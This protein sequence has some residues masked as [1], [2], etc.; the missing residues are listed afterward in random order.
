[1]DRRLDTPLVF[2]KRQTPKI[3]GSSTAF[4]VVVVVLVL[5]IVISCTAVAYL[6][7]ESAR[8]DEEIA[9][10][11]NRN[12]YLQPSASYDPSHP[13]TSKKW[14]SRI[15]GVFSFQRRSRIARPD[16]SRSMLGHSSQGWIQAG[17]GNDWD[18]DS[19]EALPTL[20]NKFNTTRM[21]E[22]QQSP[23]ATPRSSLVGAYSYT[24][25]PRL[26]SPTSD[27]ASSIRYDPHGVRGLNPD[28]YSLSPQPTLQSIQSQLYSPTS[29]PALSPV[30]RLTQSPVPL[31]I[32]E[33]INVNDEGARRSNPQSQSAPTHQ[34]FGGGT[35]FIEAL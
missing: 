16:K 4:I 22:Q 12:R 28:Q 25:A 1:M 19:Q 8:E 26:S 11:Q 33:P 34:T 30:P 24:A 29:S 32:S 10:R 9:H 21:T 18:S 27:A 31:E 13:L 20:K 17:N 23:I 2:V 15:S 5:I 35:K 6:L 14:S 3:A 7:R